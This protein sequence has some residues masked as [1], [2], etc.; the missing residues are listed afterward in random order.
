MTTQTIQEVTP[1]TH[2]VNPCAPGHQ[3]RTRCGFAIIGSLPNKGL[4][5]AHLITT[6]SPTCRQCAQD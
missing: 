3:K 2:S 1:T 4:P 6:D 5:Q